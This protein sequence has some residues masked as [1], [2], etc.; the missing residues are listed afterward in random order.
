MNRNERITP[1]TLFRSIHENRQP[2][3]LDDTWRDK[4]MDTI[5]TEQATPSFLSALELLAPRFA[6]GA[7]AVALILAI[8][9]GLALDALPDTVYCAYASH[10]FDIT[11]LTML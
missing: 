4:V 9:T 6:V 11:P 5:R 8:A 10:V 2:Q 7:T 1:M 3:A